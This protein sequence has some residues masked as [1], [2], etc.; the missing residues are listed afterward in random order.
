MHKLKAPSD[1]PKLERNILDE[2][3][4]N[5]KAFVPPNLTIDELLP[6]C[7]GF[8]VVLDALVPIFKAPVEFIIRFPV[9]VDNVVSIVFDLIPALKVGCEITLIT[10]GTLVSPMLIV[11]LFMFNV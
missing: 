8:A 7:I 2:L 10:D 1:G 9:S 6:I 5:C 11:L 4:V 3:V